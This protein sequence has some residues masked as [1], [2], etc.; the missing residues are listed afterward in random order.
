MQG[1]PLLAY[2]ATLLLA[3]VADQRASLLQLG[4]GDIL[5]VTPE[6][7]AWAIPPDPKL[8]GGMTTSLCLPEASEDFRFGSARGSGVSPI[9]LLLATDG[10][11]NSFADEASFLMVG[12]DVWRCADEGGLAGVAKHLGG[13]LEEAA[14]FS[15]DDASAAVVSL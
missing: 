6:G 8:F 13:W 2:G 1:E 14:S 9:L 11:R 3:L 7:A 12:P 15:G 5:T 10:F 4:D